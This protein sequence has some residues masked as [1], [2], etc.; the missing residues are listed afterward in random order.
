MFTLMI[1][2]IILYSAI[3]PSLL[4]YVGPGAG[5][6][7]LGALWGVLVAIV[8]ALW[9]VLYWPLRSLLRR[10]RPSEHDPQESTDSS[11]VDADEET[12]I[13]A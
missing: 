4:A 5:I 11:T 1:G 3:P 7:M 6:T 9:A 8:V 10:R 12:R 13:N 2:R